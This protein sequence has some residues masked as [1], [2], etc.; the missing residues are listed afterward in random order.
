MSMTL[1]K[2]AQYNSAK[3]EPSFMNCDAKYKQGL[4]SP[5]PVCIFS[6]W[7]HSGVPLECFHVPSLH[8]SNSVLVSCFPVHATNANTQLPACSACNTRGLAKPLCSQW[9][10]HFSPA[11]TDEDSNF[12]P[13]FFFSQQINCLV[14]IQSWKRPLHC[15]DLCPFHT[16]ESFHHYFSTEKSR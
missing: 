3:R 7:S 8:H 10:S 15:L 5:C 11:F 6:N 16:T 13:F 9:S 4:L 2:W 1:D 12:Q 14:L